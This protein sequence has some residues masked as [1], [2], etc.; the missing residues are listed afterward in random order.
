MHGGTLNP[1]YNIIL[2]GWENQYSV[3]VYRS[4]PVHFHEKLL[5]S[6]K[7]RGEAWMGSMDWCYEKISDGLSLNPLRVIRSSVQ[8]HQRL[9]ATLKTMREFYHCG[10]DGLDDE[11]LDSE[12]YK[13][14]VIL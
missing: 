2:Y 4:P 12:R 7:S 1:V 11:A 9:F 14:S 8:V 5:T 6:I 3:M 10:G 13:V